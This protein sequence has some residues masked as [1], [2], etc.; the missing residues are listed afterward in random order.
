MI[1]LANILLVQSICSRKKATP[2]TFTSHM[3]H[4]NSQLH[5]NNHHN[6]HMQ[7]SKT[8]NTH[9]ETGKKQS[10]NERMNKTVLSITFM[11][12]AMTLPSACASFLFDTLLTTDYGNFIIVLL[13]CIS[14]SY[15]GLNF[16]IMTFSNT[17]FR[18]EF[19][20]I[21]FRK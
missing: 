17:M 11:F 21:L 10:R 3:L 12:I 4:M 14:F 8:S 1:A 2:T 18:K 20:K 5:N 7:T 16:I 13:D 9:L 19:F 15:H 6:N